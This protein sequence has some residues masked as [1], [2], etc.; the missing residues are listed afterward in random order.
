MTLIQT[1]RLNIDE[2]TVNDID[3]IIEI[4]SHPENRNYL[5]IG[6]YEEHKDEITD[7][8]HMLLLFHEK[9]TGETKGYALIRLNFKSHIFE[10]RRIAITDKGKGYGR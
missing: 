1:D 9:T 2:A 10:I 4:E 5:W 7:P 8:C 6:T 3:E